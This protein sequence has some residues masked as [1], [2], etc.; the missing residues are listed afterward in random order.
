MISGSL[1]FVK[2]KKIKEIHMK[3]TVS[4]ISSDPPCGDDKAW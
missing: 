1:F 3:G 2:E 4:V